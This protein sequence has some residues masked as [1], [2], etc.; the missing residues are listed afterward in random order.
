VNTAPAPRGCDI[1]CTLVLTAQTPATIVLQI[2]T[3]RQ[4]GAT[5]SERLAVT[6]AGSPALADELATPGGRQHLLRVEPGTVNIRYEARITAGRTPPAGT[7]VTP[8]ERIRA[9]R[10]SRYSPSD[11]LVGFA[12]ARFGALPTGPHRVRAICDYVWRQVAY[13]AGT[14]ESTTDAV[15]TLLAARGVCRDFA[16]LVAALCR[17]VG[18]PARI[19]SVYAPGLSPMDFHAVVE[20]EID[21]YWQAWDATRSA[22]RQSMLRIATGRDAADIA[23]TS[24]IAGRAELTCMEI[25]AITDGDLPLDDHDQILA[26][27]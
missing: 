27:G 21:G 11:R 23:F 22:P 2:A 19:T 15:D 25:V 10:P 8:E 4:D 16:H 14:S 1:G 7:P 18:V 5:L 20:T 3:A 6:N 24:V 13:Q 9:L 17:A 12:S 26:L